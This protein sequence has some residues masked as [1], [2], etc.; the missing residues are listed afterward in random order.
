[1]RS[2]A[3]CVLAA[4]AVAAAPSAAFAQGAGDDQYTDPF[5]SE[6]QAPAPTP[7]PAPAPT[8][9]PALGPTL[10]PTSV[11]APELTPEPPTPADGPQGPVADSPARAKTPAEA[12]FREALRLMD[13]LAGV[14]VAM[15]LLAEA[16]QA[17]A[18]AGSPSRSDSAPAP[19]DP[20]PAQSP[21]PPLTGAAPSGAAGACSSS[22]GSASL[23]ALVVA[24]AACAGGLWGQLQLVPVSWRSVTLVSLNER[25]G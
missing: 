10:E 1:M 24:R 16:G 19:D 12:I 22:G 9:E 21:E 5:G 4:V 17:P 23:Y 8:P 25:P 18:A 2:R 14:R 3:A 7:E 6:E 11:P 20:S 13:D 15:A